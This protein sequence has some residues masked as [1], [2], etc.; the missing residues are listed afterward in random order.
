MKMILAITDDTICGEVSDALL[1]SNYR[2][3]QLATSGKFLRSGATTFMVG[4]D[5]EEVENVLQTI[6]KAVPEQS[7]E[8]DKRI[9]IYVLNVRNFNQL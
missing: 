9:T 3:T 6:R 2:V 1:G 4:V 8:E 7:E 5:N